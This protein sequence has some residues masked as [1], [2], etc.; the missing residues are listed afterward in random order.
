MIYITGDTHGDQVRFIENNLGDSSWTE[1]DFLIICGDFGYI[2]RNSP[3]ENEFLDYLET[4]PYTICFC[5]GNHENFPAIFSYPEEIWHSGRIHRIRKNV[6]H[7]MRGQVFE[8]EGKKIF[9]MGGAYSLD[10]GSRIP[11]CSYWDEEL[12]SDEE[13]RE[14]AENL[15]KH[16]FNVDCIITHTAPRKLIKKMG[17][18]PICYETQLTDFHFQDAQ[19]TGFLEWI[20]QTANYRHWYFGHFHLDDEIDSKHTAVLFKVHRLDG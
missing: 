5:D 2:F 9:T 15:K 18:Y 7:L 12:P 20:M 19:L 14:A 10:R 16:D 1:N 8:I 6:I 17:F 3:L 13:F 11:G 4:K